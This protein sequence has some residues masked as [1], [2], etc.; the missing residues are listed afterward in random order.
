MDRS[1]LYHI[2]PNYT[3]KIYEVNNDIIKKIINYLSLLYGSKIA[4][5]YY[6]EVV[7]LIKVHY[8][9][10]SKE[11]ELQE[12]LFNKNELFSEKDTVLI[13]YG[14]VIKDHYIKP[15]KILHNFAKKY[16]IEAFNTIH[17]LPFFPY[18]SDRGFSIIDYEQVNPELGTWQDILNIKKDFNLMFDVVLN[19]VSSKSSWFQEFLNGH[20]YYKDFFIQ[21][22]TKNIISD[23]QLKLITRPRT[24][25]L[26]TEFATI[27]GI[28]LVW[29]TF[30]N[31]QIDLNYKNPEVLLKMLHIILYYIRK[32]ANIIRL[33]AV[34]Y[35]WETLGTNCAHLNQTHTI[36]KLIRAILD[37]ASP[38]TLIITETNVPHNDNIKYFGNGLDE[39]HMVYNFALPPLVL[40]TYLKQNSKKLTLWARKLD[41][42]SQQTT[43][44]NFLDSHDGIGVFPV[45]GILTDSEIDFLVLKTIEHGGYISYR[46]D[47]DGNDAPYELNI[48]WYSAIN[49]ENSLETDDLQIKRFLSSRS[50]ALVLSGVP[51][52]YIHSFFGSKNDAESVL[53]EKQT[54]SINRKVLQ[55]KLISNLIVDHESTTYKVINGFTKLL[56]IRSKEAL[57]HPNCGQIILNLSENVFAVIR[58]SNDKNIV[59]IT[60]VTND[61]IELN[62][63]K[64]NFPHWSR[65]WEDL[66]TGNIY[67]C[68]NDFMNLKLCPYEILWLKSR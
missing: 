39:A 35:L 62:I 66:L 37:V 59:C 3:K 53:I 9:Y 27:N 25:D 7:R 65:E 6:Q 8:A 19:H 14:D 56:K 64:L 22:T 48:T 20:P 29:T 42:I 11:L 49:N 16:F 17:I 41:K 33:D 15:L 68:D 31:D 21:F 43:F 12:K 44:F 30:S 46:T 67:K 51:G 52:V 10:K 63:D 26:F 4:T 38:G 60:N 13:T 2:T 58:F 61:T 34:T 32:G 45:K 55:K 40:F 24:S 1:E 47:Q 23:D 18:S 36:I 5:Q 28:K 54:R 50:I 57:F